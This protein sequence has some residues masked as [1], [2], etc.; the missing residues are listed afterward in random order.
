LR[1][2]P[3]FSNGH[4]ARVNKFNGLYFTEPD[5]LGVAI[6]DVAFEDPPI[7]GIEIH[8][9]EGAD[10]DTGPAA[11]TGIVVNGHAAQLLI[12][13]DGLDRTNI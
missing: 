9:T 10:A 2:L 3:A 1:G 13:D 11:N 8:G 4:L 12:P 7:G 5:A 6:T